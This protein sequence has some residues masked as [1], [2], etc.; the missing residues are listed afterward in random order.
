MVI[1][2][3]GRE[4][5]QFVFDYLEKKAG[6]NQAAALIAAQSYFFRDEKSDQDRLKLLKKA[7]K[8]SDS[9]IAG[10]AYYLLANEFMAAGDTGKRVKEALVNSAELGNLYAAVALARAYTD[11]TFG[12]KVDVEQAYDL[13]TDAYDENFA[14]AKL[15]LAELLLTTDID[16][17]M[18]DPMGL[19]IEAVEEGVEGAE[20]VLHSLTAA[21]AR[22]AANDDS[23]DNIKLSEKVVPNGFQR[24]LHLKAAILNEF[25][26]DASVAEILIAHWYGFDT[27]EELNQASQSKDC[28]PGRFD[29]DCDPMRLKARIAEQNQITEQHIDAPPNVLSLIVE[30]LKPTSRAHPPSLRKLDGLVS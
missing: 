4:T 11:G 14:P 17:D 15:A 18:H 21:I 9:N 24:V 7:A 6:R 25:D 19:L 22:E 29:E 13:L 23:G 28:P 26:C 2:A 12:C 20:E 10:S 16:D 1:D 5:P 27:W 8:G 30:L 3:M